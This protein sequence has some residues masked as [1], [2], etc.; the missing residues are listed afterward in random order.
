MMGVA[1]DSIFDFFAMISKRVCACAHPFSYPDSSHSELKTRKCEL[2][3][4]RPP[5]FVLGLVE[6]GDSFHPALS[7]SGEFFSGQEIF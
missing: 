7:G 3:P 5:Q 6:I 1:A 4:D 2:L